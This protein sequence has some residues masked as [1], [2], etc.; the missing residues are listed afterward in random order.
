MDNQ[1][2]FGTELKVPRPVRYDPTRRFGKQDQMDIL[3]SKIM[4]AQHVPQSVIQTKI[5][6]L[7]G[8]WENKET[9]ESIFRGQCERIT[10]YGQKCDRSML[11]QNIDRPE[12]RTLSMYRDRNDIN[13]RQYCISSQT[14]VK[15]LIPM[16]FHYPKRITIFL[17]DI[18]GQTGQRIREAIM[19]VYG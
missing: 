11:Y 13:C 3:L 2:Q 10:N 5:K 4:S 15:W 16:I 19:P 18:S 14:I 6:P 8:E 1:N 9:G 12:D 17:P 7:L